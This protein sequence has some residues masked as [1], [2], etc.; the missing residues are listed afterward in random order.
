MAAR[1]LA[2]LAAGAALAAAAGCGGDAVREKEDFVADAG[3]ICEDLKFELRRVTQARDL[4]QL[5]ERLDDGAEA[6][7][8]A[9]A[10]MR[11]LA[12]PED[13]GVQAARRFVRHYTRTIDASLLPAM[14]RARAATRRG[15]AEGARRAL[16]SA[17][18]PRGDRTRSLAIELGIR[19]CT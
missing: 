7:R 4:G 3:L 9:S 2:V 15:D 10:R 19:R 14:L 8:D 12:L 18:P 16:R 6:L 13:R 11:R 5:S 17:R 1:R